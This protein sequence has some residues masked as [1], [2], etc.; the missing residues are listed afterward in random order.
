MSD[1]YERLGDELAAAADRLNSVAGASRG[2][3]G[4]LSNRLHAVTAAAV[5]LLGGG[6]VALAATGLLS[7]AP[8]KPEVPLNPAAGNGL[9][10]AGAGSHI[11]LTAEDPAGGLPWGMRIERTT[12]GETCVQVGRIDGGQLGQLG[13]DSG[14]ANDGRFHVLPATVLPPGYGGASGQVECVQS[15][16]TMIFEDPK[17]DRSAVRL[18][19]IEFS[20]PPPAAGKLPTPKLPPTADLRVLAYGLLGPHA[21]D[22]TYR[23]PT[24]LRTIPVTGPDGAFLVVEPAGYIVSNDN[25]GGSSSGSAEARSVDVLGPLGD[26]RSTIITAATFR[27][28]NRLCSQGSGGPAH[29]SCPMQNPAPRPLK[30]QHLRN[31]HE[32]IGLTLL[33]QSHAEC[34]AAYLNYPCYK[35][36]LEFTAPYAVT[37]TASDY[38]VEAIA[39]CRAG[40]RPETAWGLERNVK[41]GE[42][43]R[44]DSLGR[45]V[46]TP[47]CAPSEK[48]V[49]RYERGAG[50]AAFNPGVILGEVSLLQAR[51]PGGEPAGR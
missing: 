3:R 32:P 2:L 34:D 41:A 8:V 42:L 44:T 47:S 25:I 20:G 14:F 28:G 19:P 4:W 22:V 12:R 50:P 9:P 46:Y 23:A 11:A 7:G 33:A 43:V 1:P 39:R 45:F 24:G 30:P 15:G 16:Q 29:P 18:L 5:L 38:S 10:V 13:L 37:S 26:G 35:G 21:V 48:F 40:G 36:Q 51:L 49:V 27:F 31:L 17:A 6:A